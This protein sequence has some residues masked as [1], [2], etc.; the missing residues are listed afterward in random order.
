MTSLDVVVG[1]VMA[2][3]TTAELTSA[4][5]RS[6]GRPTVF[7]RSLQE[8]EVVAFA[9]AMTGFQLPGQDRPIEVRVGTMRPVPGL[10]ETVRLGAD[11]TLTSYRN[12]NDFGLVLVDLD[13]FSDAQGL[14]NL[15]TLDDST[16]LADLDDE[17]RAQR[18]KTIVECAWRWA[19]P[20]DVR[21]QPP[22]QLVARFAE[23]HELLSRL[24]TTS[25]RVWVQFALEAAQPLV[26]EDVAVHSSIDRAVGSAL[27]A[28]GLFPDEQLFLDPQS[29]KKRLQDNFHL[30]QL[31]QPGGREIQEDELVEL[32]KV[33]D[34][35]PELLDSV[36][37]PDESDARRRMLAVAEGGQTT[38]RAEVPF[39]LWL[40]LFAVRPDRASLG[41]RIKSVY[42][43]Q[44]DDRVSEFDDLGV[45]TGLDNG[46]REAAEQLLRADPPGD[47]RPLAELL[48]STLRRRIEKLATPRAIAEGDPLRA[49]LFG[50]QS[51]ERSSASEQR[52]VTLSRESV[53]DDEGDLSCAVFAFLYGPTLRDIALTA[54]DG[55]G[56]RIEVDD[57][58]TTVTPLGDLKP[59]DADSS[60]DN[61]SRW[62]PLRLVLSADGQM[63]P[64]YRFQ[65]KPLDNPGLVALAALVAQ[66]AAAIGAYLDETLDSWALKSLDIQ[67][68]LDGSLVPVAPDPPPGTVVGEWLRE[69]D[70]LHLALSDGGLDEATIAEYVSDWG[71]ILERA[72]DELVPQ[73]SPLP[74]LDAFLSV[75]VVR[76][77]GNRLA[78][79]G[80]H[81]LRLRWFASHL[82]NMKRLVVG[83]LETGLVLNE[84]NDQLFFDWLDRVSPHRQ[85]PFISGPDQQLA[86]PI[87]E[88]GLH[89]EYALIHAGGAESRDWLSGIDD[90]SVDAITSVVRNYLDAYPHKRDGLGLLLLLRD[91][92]PAVASRL[93]RQIRNKDYLDARVVLHVLTGRKHHD[94]ITREV[95]DLLAMGSSIPDR[96]MPDVELVLYDW[97]DGEAEPDLTRLRETI[98]V[99]IAPNLFGT[100]TSAQPSTRRRDSGLAGRFDPWVDASSHD[101][102]LTRGASENVSTVLLP[103]QPDPMLEAWSTLSVRRFRNASVSPE[104]DE[105]TDYIALQVQF[106][107]GAPL[108][109]SLHSVAHWVVTLDPFVGRD[110]ID[111]LP[112][113]PD[114]ILVRGGVG[115]NRTYTLVV[116]SKTGSQHVTERLSRKLDHDLHVQLPAPSPEIA[117]RLY[118]VGRNSFPGVM[119][120]A[121]GLGR[122]AEEVLGLI[123][124]RHAVESA[125]PSPS[126]V[127]G[128]EWWISLDERT[129]WFGGSQRSRADLL[130]VLAIFEEDR[131]AIRL[132]VVESKFRSVEDGAVLAVADQQL[133]RTIALFGEA[134]RGASDAAEEGAADDARFWMRELVDALDQTSKASLPASE[135]PALRTWGG[136]SVDRLRSALLDGEVHV[137]E[138]VG[139][140]VGIAY[141]AAGPAVHGVTDQGH[142]LLR[143]CAPEL[144]AT[145]IAL[146][147]PSAQDPAST[148]P[149]EP[150][151]EPQVSRLPSLPA[152]SSS[153]DGSS[154]DGEGDDGEG[155]P[156]SSGLS[157]QIGMTDG[158]LSDRYQRVL[159]VFA[160]HNVRVSPPESGYTDQGPGF[161]V[162]RLVPDVGVS[163]DKLLNRSEDLKLALRLEA[164][165]H[166]RAFVDRGAVVLEVPKTDDERYEVLTSSLWTKAPW[167]QDQL[168]VPLGED[169]NGDVVGIDFS[170]A[171]SPH[172]LI[173]GATGSGKSVLIETI[174]RGATREFS[175]EALRLHLV[176]PK[177][178]ELIDFENSPH[179]EGSIGFSSED[180]IEL[181]ERA[182]EEMQRRYELFR[183]ARVRSLIDYNAAADVSPLPWWLLVL[184]EYADLTSDPDDKG[185]IE[186][187]LKRLAQKARAAGVHLLVATQK[188]SAEVISTTVRS[189]LPA[190]IALRVKTSSD[191]RIIMDEAGA[192]SL[193]GKGDAFLRTARGLTRFQCARYDG[194]V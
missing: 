87:R 190:Q 41:A 59:T 57:L 177:G 125:Y 174:L 89:E 135:L 33:V 187:S 169:I 69:R 167:E 104:A 94:A 185:R 122:A 173:G 151:A 113:R 10:A 39:A 27:A 188:P 96:F 18:A 186:R 162:L 2:D 133:S 147:N 194:D 158:A 54:A 15:R 146:L 109:E 141:G 137:D 134:F 102:R 145:L 22:H 25:L 23:V 138:I 35:P 8:S 45:E 46:E 170:S 5:R 26:L 20:D 70:R 123:V 72:R 14:S 51:L 11:C 168:Y 38:E 92:D 12:S 155:R 13:P 95:E 74:E 19:A 115:K 99:A 30:A 154:P 183:A 129:D 127:D 73:G 29:L 144:E 56:A 81:P 61:A 43:D 142:Q 153:D 90:S 80:S 77:A 32:V 50:L 85:P 88:S 164:N 6:V 71:D 37:V 62:S 132:H 24:G 119:L 149:P 53:L 28:V 112:G 189:N 16:V 136:G 47:E 86:I 160:A 42:E 60:T 159:D 157:P 105:S 178:T 84:Q 9:E 171:N 130:R 152:K 36:G 121:L 176:D 66:P 156:A 192:E 100:K 120:R 55:V 103:S 161:Y 140:A 124:S 163:V 67:A 118:Q 78:L 191:S 139:I 83:S 64:L 31:K 172:V 21:S 148:A 79:L 4:N 181:L 91:G 143:V 193:A 58:L 98:D 116:S 150:R 126:T 182:V 108:F 93:L 76:T 44:F 97:A 3:L 75:D 48:P 166:I 114:V 63:D 117:E 65:W 17:V 179:L 184:D 107:A 82:E 7:V 165:Q 106:H 52:V 34:L 131:V 68:W 110:Q 1:R 180:A 128:V 49:L 175:P 40:H 101:L 111:A